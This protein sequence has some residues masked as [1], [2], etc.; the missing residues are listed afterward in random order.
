M[1]ILEAIA[2][3][4]RVDETLRIFRTLGELFGRPVVLHYIPGNH[5]RL[6]NASP[7][8][9]IKVRELLG[10]EKSGE[11]F[12]HQYLHYAQGKAMVF[13]RHGHEYDSSNFGENLISF[14]IPPH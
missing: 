4:D 6:L 10:Q 5:D 7:A 14:E 12:E 3:D 11:P 9:R 13:V 8:I 2:A 1:E